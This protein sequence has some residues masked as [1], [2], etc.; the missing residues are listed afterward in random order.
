M[1]K[2]KYE[3]VMD[4]IT[5]DVR[6]QEKLK[7]LYR[8]EMQGE[9]FSTGQQTAMEQQAGRK[10]VA[11]AF[12]RYAAIA[13]SA[14]ACVMAATLV[15]T[16]NAEN[17]KNEMSL[18]HGTDLEKMQTENLTEYEHTFILKALM[19]DRDVTGG[20][21]MEKGKPVITTGVG[22][23]GNGGQK[24]ADSD[25]YT[26]RSVF[27]FRCEGDHIEKIT[28][29]VNKGFLQICEPKNQD[30]IAIEAEQ[31]PYVDYGKS[32]HTDEEESQYWWDDLDNQ[33][34]YSYTVAYDK[35]TAPYTDF[36]V[37]GEKKMEDLDVE[38]LYK[39]YFPDLTWEEFRISDRHV[40][41]MTQLLGDVVITCTV[42]FDDG[43]S[44]SADIKVVPKVMTLKE[45][46]FGERYPDMSEEDLAV[47]E[48][49]I[50]Y[51]MQ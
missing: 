48:F 27:S 25:E 42:H 40:D 8:S 51:E 7:A 5:L 29:S 14:A 43:T 41:A 12:R 36:S 26:Y 10:G 9:N 24:S 50:A 19:S 35:Q 23:G 20:V 6:M 39:T 49:F 45:A 32:I 2:S 22:G 18:N 37:C 11:G 13:A 47:R 38:G 34:Y 1:S 17:G 28:Y 3:N 46:G 33:I 31:A 15:C 30:S 44:E 4:Q 21:I 16:Q